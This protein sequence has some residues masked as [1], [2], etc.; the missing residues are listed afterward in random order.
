MST[1]TT[2]VFSRNT[3]SRLVW[4]LLLFLPAS[5]VLSQDQNYVSY[6]Q[7]I[8]KARGKVIQESYHDALITYIDIFKSF[9]FQFARDCINA[10]ELAA[11]LNNKEYTAYFITQSIKRGVPLSYF[12]EGEKFKKFKK[13][14]LWPRVVQSAETWYKE[15]ENSIDLPMRQ[16]INTMFHADQKIRKA[17][18]RWYNILWKTAIGKKWKKLNQQQVERIAEMTKSKGFPGEKLIGI[19]RPTDHPNVQGSLFSAG[20]PIVILIHHF[21]QPNPSYDDLLLPEVSKG[22]LHNFHFATVCDFQAKYGQ[23]QYPHQGPYGISFAL[24]SRAPSID[25]KRE[26]IGL[27]SMAWMSAHQSQTAII[28]KFWNYLY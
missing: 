19:D 9:D 10:A 22:N 18:Y 8:L 4:V 14:P 27:P 2:W 6:H 7:M 17:Y 1:A 25:K 15:Y 12:A 5:L 20:M 26:E 3:I 23:G 28:T 13:S 24:D 11:F 21:S 16:E